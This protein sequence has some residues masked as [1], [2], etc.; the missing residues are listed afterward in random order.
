MQL[1]KVDGPQWWQPSNCFLE[2]VFWSSGGQQLPFSWLPSNTGA[3]ISKNL[4]SQ[5]PQCSICC[6]SHNDLGLCIP[7]RCYLQTA[8]KTTFSLKIGTT[9]WFSERRQFPVQDSASWG[10]SSKSVWPVLEMMP[11]WENVFIGSVQCK[12]RTLQT[13][14][15]IP[16]TRHNSE[17]TPWENS[18]HKMKHVWIS[19]CFKLCLPVTKMC[20][21]YMIQKQILAENTVCDLYFV[22]S[23]VPVTF[24][25]V[26]SLRVLPG[27][28][29]CTSTLGQH[30]RSKMQRSQNSPPPPQK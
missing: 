28:H 24:G 25:C 9:V 21:I 20:N 3:Q 29:C 30:E 22:T 8:Q 2:G 19:P 26:Y 5:V 23:Y 13:D 17:A 16:G 4:L 27:S 18:F 12:V 7:T 15:S 14:N 10:Y 6:P 1:Q 11:T